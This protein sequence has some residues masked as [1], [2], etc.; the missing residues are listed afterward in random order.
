MGGLQRLGPLRPEVL[1][2]GLVLA[3]PVVQLAFQLVA[4]VDED[5]DRHPHAEVRSHRRVHRDQRELQCVLQAGID[6]GRAIENRLAVFVLADLQV[7]RVG[8]GLDEVAGRVDHEQP[9]APFADLAGE[10][11][12]DVETAALVLQR[13]AVDPVDLA[14]DAA[15]EMGGL[16]HRG[17]RPDRVLLA[18]RGVLD[19]L[20]GVAED[21]LSRGEVAGRGHGHDALPLLLEDVELAE[22]RDVVEPGI[23]ARVGDDDDAVTDEKANAIGHLAVRRKG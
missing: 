14:H 12:R 7:G 23:R 2:V 6:R 20:G 10:Q 19:P 17:C 5:V 18:G 21:R 8:G 9:G 13:L 1:E 3:D 4:A 11:D 15:D 16:E 22:R